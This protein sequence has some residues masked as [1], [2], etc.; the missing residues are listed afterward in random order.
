MA[1]TDL[2]EVSFSDRDRLLLQQL[3]TRQ[4]LAERRTNQAAAS[5]SDDEGDERISHVPPVEPEIP[6]KWRLIGEAVTLHDWQRDCLA[7]WLA[8]GRGTVKVATG[9]QDHL[10]PCRRADTPERTDA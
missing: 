1:N 2:L 4:S 8:L 9:R 3:L 10:C 5:D 7:K 6:A